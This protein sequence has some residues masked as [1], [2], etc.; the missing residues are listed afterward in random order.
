M[1]S[2]RIYIASSWRNVLYFPL[3]D[4]LRAMGHEVF[5]WRNPPDGRL[6]F[7]WDELDPGWEG[8]TPSEY[9]LH[10]LQNPRAIEGFNSDM[11]GLN[12]CDTCILLLPCGNSAHLEAGYAVGMGKSVY[13]LLSEEGFKPDLMYRMFHRI[14]HRE[15]DLLT[16]LR[17]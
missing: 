11:R 9:V 2:H 6:P 3:R 12:W 13:C 5:D 8:W 17:Y 16:R 1:P 10:L 14:Y 7:R 4:K 15:E